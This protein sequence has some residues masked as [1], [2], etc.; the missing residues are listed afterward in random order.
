ME[1]I[2]KVLLG[3]QTPDNNRRIVG[4]FNRTLDAKALVG[5]A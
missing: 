4:A 2:S 3:Y 1:I 5:P